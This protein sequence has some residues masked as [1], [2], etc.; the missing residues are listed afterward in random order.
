MQ[1]FRL[2]R[3]KYADTLSGKGAAIRGARW[4]SKGVEVIYTATNRSLAM[5]EVA[6]HLSLATL[7]R[8]Y[9]MMTIYVPDGISRKKITVDELP[10]GWNK[11]P[12]LNSTQIIGDRFILKNE[13]CLLYV[14]SAV[15]KGDYNVMINLNHPDYSE[16]KISSVEP[17]P[18]DR[19]IFE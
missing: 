14:P 2:S 8:D 12:Y 6:V 3:L 7:P 15:T 11:H 4:N 17:F 1:L 10:T 16:I 19:R 5:A 9:M 13:A 18:F